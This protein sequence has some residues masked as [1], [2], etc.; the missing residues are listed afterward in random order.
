MNSKEYWEQREAEALK[1][2]I[3]DEKEY[4]KRIR[5]IYD[6][7]LHSVQTEINA[8][9]GKYAYKNGIT[10]A[11]AK[12]AVKQADIAAYKFK[13][14]QYVNDAA[15]DRKANGGKT[16]KN[17]Y[18]FSDKANEEMAL[19]N[20][21]MKVNRLEMLK[22]NIGLELIKGHAEL[23]TFMN[24]ILQGRTMDE[25][26]RQAGI[27]GKTIQ[28]NAQLA[29]AIVNA[30]FHNATFSDRIWQYQDLMKNQL[31]STLQTGLIQGKNPRAIA[32]ELRRYWY[33]N[34]P[35]TGKGAV[36]CMERL[37][38]TELAR[39]QTEAQKQSFEKNGFEMYTFHTNTGCCPVCADL[40][41][42]HFKISEM[43]PGKNAA[44]MHPNCRCSCSAYED[45]EEYEQWLDFLA[46]GGTTEQWNKQKTQPK[47]TK[48]KSTISKK[49]KSDKIIVEDIKLG[50]LETAYGK[51]H[52]E[53][54]RKHLRNAPEKARAIW[55]KCADY[56]HCLDPKYRGNG[57]AYYPRNDGVRLNIS[58][59]A[60]GTTYQTPYQVV[61]HEFGHHADYVLN[62]LFGNKDNL[63][64]FTETYKDGIFGKTIKKEANAAIDDFAKTLVK[65]VNPDEIRKGFADWVRVGFMTEEEVEA[66][67]ARELQKSKM[68]DRQVVEG[69]FCQKIKDE[70]TLMQRS[71]ISDMFEPVM[72][73]GFPFGVGHG[74]NY[75]KNRDN[76]KEGFAEMYS[77]MI[78]NPESWE[79]IQRFFP[80]SCKIFDEMLNEVLKDENIR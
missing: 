39:V 78:N 33:G 62:R 61:F 1:H 46:N 72:S 71:D 7:M 79:Q 25:L 48:Q 80:E 13:A 26:K 18:Y 6:D 8:F 60:K 4:E 75:W 30:S 38:R 12:K 32:G 16:N 44:P 3:K 70:L 36:Y 68:P 28:N 21:T 31:S 41:G 15:K 64:A 14:K 2:Y 69:L 66:E 20:L 67:I 49:Q 59:A 55:N 19:Y 22:A 56:F 37:M 11:E 24:D 43:M 29:H 40:D 27:L 77:A 42:K 76:G 17:G 9:Y 5:Q 35:K 23:E 47:A 63:K 74:K 51:K 73:T 10:I 54:I 53:A 50:E 34:D 57:A 52:S 45:S 58:K 65:Q